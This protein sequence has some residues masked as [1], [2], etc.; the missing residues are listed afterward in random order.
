[1]RSE[2]SENDGKEAGESDIGR[3]RCR[4]LPSPCVGNKH[5]M[6]PFPVNT[7]AL[8]ITRSKRLGDVA[9]MLLFMIFIANMLETTLLKDF[10]RCYYTR[11]L[12]MKRWSL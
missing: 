3:H 8:D 5:D 9:L 1:M 4:G 2:M 12:Y 7:A 11:M 6:M 10:S